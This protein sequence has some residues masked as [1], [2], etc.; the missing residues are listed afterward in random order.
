[1]PSEIPQSI[2]EEETKNELSIHNYQEIILL[3]ILGISSIYF[4]I[5]S[6]LSLKFNLILVAFYLVGGF[7]VFRYISKNLYKWR[8]YSNSFHDVSYF[9]KKMGTFLNIKEIQDNVIVF[10]DNTLSA[11]IRAKPIDGSI[12]DDAQIDVVLNVYGSILKS[13]PYTSHVFSHSVLPNLDGFFESNN[14]KIVEQKGD[15]GAKL[16]NKKKEQKW[17]L[18]KM[19]ASQA[20]DREN[21]FAIMLKRKTSLLKGFDSILYLFNLKTL[22]EIQKNQVSAQINKRE[23]IEINNLIHNVA[24]EFEKIGVMT[25]QLNNNELIDLYYSYF[26]GA[27]GVG[28]SNLQSIMWLKEE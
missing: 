23:F 4:F 11:M 18:T 16:E 10:N 27:K 25:H 8:L 24:G 9:D 19:Q 6:P 15:Y 28:E 1:M 5:H 3:F 13:I 2:Y 12:L 21:Y 26:I 20:R 14:R 22:D 17:L 7:E